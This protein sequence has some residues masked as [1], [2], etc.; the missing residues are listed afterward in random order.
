MSALFSDAD[1]ARMLADANGPLRDAAWSSG[2]IVRLIY[3][4]QAL[5]E[6]IA[7]LREANRILQ[8]ATVEMDLVSGCLRI[9]AK[10]IRHT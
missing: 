8:E 10:R 5:R 4:I 6:E 1:L 9:A 7:H 2:K 3:E